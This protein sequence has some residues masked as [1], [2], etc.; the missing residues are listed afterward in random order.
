MVS[1]DAKASSA[2]LPQPPTPL[3]PTTTSTHKRKWW[4]FLRRAKPRTTTTSAPNTKAIVTSVMPVLMP[5]HCM[6]FGC[7]HGSDTDWLP[8]LEHYRPIFPS[9]TT[10]LPMPEPSSRSASVILSNVHAPLTHPPSALLVD[11]IRQCRSRATE[12]STTSSHV[13]TVPVVVPVADTASTSTHDVT[14]ALL[15][16]T[17]THAAMLIFP[18]QVDVVLPAEALHSVLALFEACCDCVDATNKKLT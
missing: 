6:L 17:S 16:C 3:P 11:M 13:F 12:A 9:I 1:V 2:R 7:R 10:S 15:P 5:E 14:V 18:Q 8:E 4:H